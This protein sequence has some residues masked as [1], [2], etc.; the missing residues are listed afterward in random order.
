LPNIST[1][2]RNYNK[3]KFN[4]TPEVSDEQLLEQQGREHSFQ[5]TMKSEDLEDTSILQFKRLC[6]NHIRHMTPELDNRM[7]VI[8]GKKMPRNTGM[9]LE[10]ETRTQKESPDKTTPLLNAL[11]ALN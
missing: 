5:Y 7:A 4:I 1:R 9:A 2:D 3:K 11:N 6:T 8:M 10:F